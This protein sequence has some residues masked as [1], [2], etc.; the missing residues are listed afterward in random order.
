MSDAFE[1]RPFPRGVLIAVASLLSFTIIMI[2]IARLT[3]VMMPQAP[4]TAEVQGRDIAFLE[5]LD[6]SMKV[7]DAQTG[8]LLQTLPPGSEGFIRG[9]LRSMARQRK[10]Y[11]AALSVP[12]RLARRANGELTLEDPVTGILMD[13]RAFGETNQAAFAVLIPEQGRGSVSAAAPR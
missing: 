2:A 8:E 9:V 3:G 10:G 4:V 13:L 12:F 5:Q 6:G 7:T 1:G 11:D